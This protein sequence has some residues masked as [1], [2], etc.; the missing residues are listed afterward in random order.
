MK[1]QQT[2]KP[3]AS[4][5]AK[6]SEQDLFRQYYPLVQA[7]VDEIQPHLKNQAD[8]RE[9]LAMASMK[10]GQLI[11]TPE[12]LGRRELRKALEQH[13]VENL[14]VK[15]PLEDP[16]DLSDA[17]LIRDDDLKG[18]R[19]LVV[20]DSSMARRQ[21][22]FFLEKDGFE[23]Y[24]AK[25]GEEALWLVNEVDPDLILMD[26]SME[27]LDG[28]E[29]CRHLKED[30]QNANLP[31]IFI[32]SKGER[33]EIVK[34]FKS[35]AID[36]I[37][38][39][40]HPTESLTRIRTQLRVK[41]LAQLR[42]KHIVELKTL[43]QTKDRILRIAS[44]DLR[45]PI[46]AIAGLAGFLKCDAENLTDGQKEIVDSIEE[47][48]KGVVNLLNELLDLSVMDSGH[49][50]LN[51][52]SVD[53]SELTRNLVPLF[54]GEAD[55]KSILLSCECPGELPRV[56]V[57]RQQIRRVADNLISNAIK[58]TPPEG[59]VTLRVVKDGQEVKFQVD[60]TGPGIPDKEAHRIFQEFGKTSNKPTG[61]E[62][63][64]GLG[65]SI[66][67]AIVE[68]HG[69]SIGFVNLPEAGARFTVALP[70]E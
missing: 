40:F 63:S 26:V 56:S 13:L 5:S 42:E 32:S 20:D 6:S 7:V 67:H 33:E 25:S 62:K 29:A 37:V 31:V 18:S 70:A 65:L 27:G 1:Q 22:Q 46:A 50:E 12:N 41:R 3:E 38:K 45:N 30:P 28:M 66:C 35:G 55:R 10:L 54:R 43:N 21:I 68:A 11:R 61:G 34:G 16:R 2:R 52:E 9:V 60:D 15:D 64:I 47:A 8:Q 23:V 58:F 14:G 59:R 4:A 24:Q 57:D 39:P 36:Y 53:L 51:R 44:H 17:S 49:K 69:G 48:G 19:I